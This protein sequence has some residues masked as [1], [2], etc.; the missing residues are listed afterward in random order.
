[1]TADDFR[2]AALALPEAVESAHMGHPDFRVGGKVFASLGPDGDWGMVKLTPDQQAESIRSG[3][4]EFE[5]AAGAWGRRGY[6][7]VTLAAAHLLSVRQALTLAWRNTAS[8]KLVK[9][10]DG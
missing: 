5:P 8:K 10:Y 2:E 1:M 4:G 3:A 7:R 6:T 9:Q